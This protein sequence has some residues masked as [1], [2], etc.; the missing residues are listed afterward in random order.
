M[1]YLLIAVACFSLAA[2]GG[3]PGSEKWC[4]EKK[5]QPKSQW[6]GEDAKTFAQHCILDSTTIGS[7]DWCAKL[8]DKDKGE[9]TT[10]E[11]AD[12]AKHCVM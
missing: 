2:C 11:A 9:W 6:T 7:E 4:Q 10:S 5:D 12:Y 1:R 3:G 8:D